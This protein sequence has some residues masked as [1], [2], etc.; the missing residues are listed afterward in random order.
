MTTQLP[1][2]IVTGATGGIGR[3]IVEGMA[4]RGAAH[5]ILA[6]RD[7]GKARRLAA[8]FNG[9]PLRTEVM[10]LNLASFESMRTFASVIATSGGRINGLFNNAGIMPGKM[11]VTADGYEAATQVNFLAPALLSRLLI[12]FMP[13]GSGI[14]FTTSMTRYIA[15]LRADWKSRAVKHHQRFTTYGRSKLMLTHH[16]LDLSRELSTKIIRVNCSDPGIVDSAIL[17]MGN[18][19][20]DTLCDHLLR[21]RINTPA[22]GA[23]PALKA[24]FSSDTGH[25]F[26][27]KEHSPIPDTYLRDPL[28][29]SVADAVATI[30]DL[31]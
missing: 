30:A 3:A 1:V 20:I 15:R 13:P 6:C 18:R 4:A 24:M 11:T 26:T 5:V 28:H 2:Y 7:I 19:V 12:P 10:E 31:H 14:V 21:P 23:A 27:L 29:K 22:E 8:D 9:S 16:A 25:I 17:T